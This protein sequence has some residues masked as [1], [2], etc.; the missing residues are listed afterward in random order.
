MSNN[1]ICEKQRQ[2]ALDVPI[3][4]VW[5]R[6]GLGYV[7]DGETICSPFRQ[8]RHPSLQVGGKRNICYDYA[9]RDKWNTI[10]LVMHQLNC[11]YGEAVQYLNGMNPMI[12]QDDV[13]PD[14]NSTDYGRQYSHINQTNNPYESDQSQKKQWD[15]DYAKEVLKGAR[16]NLIQSYRPLQVLFDYGLSEKSIP[17]API[18]LYV[19]KYGRNEI[20]YADDL[21]EPTVVKTKSV[22][23][24]LE[25]EEG[26]VESPD[27][28]RIPSFKVRPEGGI[29]LWFPFGRV[30]GR[31][32]ILAGGEEK[33]M[34]LHEAF[35]ED[36]V[37]SSLT[38]E[39]TKL[40]PFHIDQ[41]KDADPSEV[42]V[43]F[44]ADDAGR[45]G[46]KA[47]GQQ[48][49]KAGIR[50]SVAE[51][52]EGFPKGYDVND[53]FQD[54]GL[55]P[56]LELI[57]K[58]RQ[59][60]P[61]RSVVYLDPYEDSLDKRSRFGWEMLKRF[62]NW[63]PTHPKIV[64][65][66]GLLSEVVENEKTKEIMV[67]A[68]SPKEFRTRLNEGT[69]WQNSKGKYVS[70]PSDVSD[71]L[72]HHSEWHQQLPEL[73]GIY[74]APLFSQFG[75]L[76]QSD[77]YDKGTG[78]YL[79][80]SPEVRSIQ[81]SEEP[82]AEDVEQAKRILLDELLGEFP[83]V[84][85]RGADG[86]EFEADKVNA[87][88]LILEPYV[89]EMTGKTPLYLIDKPT[90]GTGAGLL[91]K[92]SSIIADGRPAR[93]ITMDQDD[94]EFKKTLFSELLSLSRFIY[95][96]NVEY[97]IKSPTLASMLTEPEH[98]QRLLTTNTMATVEPHCSWIATGNN[99]AV[100][101]DILRRTVPVRMD[102]GL[103]RPWERSGWRHPD[104]VRWVEE[105]RSH[106]I[107]A[108]LVLVQNW[109]SSGSVPGTKKI[110]SFH[111]WC[112]VMGGIL[113]SAGIP[114]FLDN[115]DS[116]YSLNED[117]SDLG[118]FIQIWL[119]VFGDAPV[120][121]SSLEDFVKDLTLFDQRRD[122]PKQIGIKINRDCRDRIFK[123]RSESGEE[124]RVKVI[125]RKNSNQ[126][127]EYL[128][129]VQG[130]SISNDL[131]PSNLV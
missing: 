130:E 59:I 124:I 85:T 91:A 62:F 122:V 87:V 126:K 7:S 106:L 82:T 42:I 131:G 30:K 80:L 111:R 67:R 89:R 70:A 53:L 119:N 11:D 49:F 21:I 123:V 35:P 33:A 12:P 18:G 93:A 16:R 47:I 121:P 24:F 108:C 3:S 10:E 77:G 60:T 17:K 86:A 103:E 5:D 44:D 110:G 81:V 96:D 73:K 23:R 92:L 116:F 120:R 78:F 88:C 79:R 43:I 2:Q 76:V 107:W 50:T 58:A 32:L 8:D 115:L 114:G 36:T 14:F 84:K 55:E 90:H 22:E 98:T 69:D 28:K 104:L 71:Y 48:L 66:A 34:F 109:I 1:S 100:N 54:Y 112:E 101:P 74:F 117:T 27:G 46:A 56:L 105:N 40:Q 97:K 37:C 19:N 68:L 65:N 15:L 39:G 113:S 4:E 128:L 13:G 129:E 95:I 41:I 51:W 118:E 25:T 9:T 6:V 20:I 45:E 102:A 127:N 99:V 83:F 29:P 72:F 75:E 64:R 57:E 61:E 52:G 26:W 63:D 31:R 94:K 125:R 38:G